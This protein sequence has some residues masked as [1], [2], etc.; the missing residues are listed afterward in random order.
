MN[1]ESFIR[2][3]EY[4][5]FIAKKKEEETK[6]LTIWHDRLLTI[7]YAASYIYLIVF[8]AYS[9]FSMN[10]LLDNLRTGKIVWILIPIIIPVSLHIFYQVVKHKLSRY[11]K[12]THGIQ[13][14][15][16]IRNNRMAGQIL[17]NKPEFLRVFSASGKDYMAVKEG[18]FT[19]IINLTITGIEADESKDN[20]WHFA[21]K[22]GALAVAE[23]PKR[24]EA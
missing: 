21:N 9:K 7:A 12:E 3:Q 1:I 15:E 11:E 4:L 10:V 16:D 17:R 14:G 5:S 19:H 8:L 13:I 18:P 23:Y 24:R 22:D 6:S 20:N 2:K